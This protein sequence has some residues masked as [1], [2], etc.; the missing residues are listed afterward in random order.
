MKSTE[1]LLV[2]CAGACPWNYREALEHL[3]S[4]GMKEAVVDY[5]LTDASLERWCTSDSPFECSEAT[6]FKS[7][8]R[9]II[10]QQLA[11]SAASKIYGRFQGLFDDID[12]TPAMVIDKGMEI[13]GVGLSR[14]KAEFILDLSRAMTD[15]RVQADKIGSMCNADLSAMLCS[16]RGIGQWTCDMYVYFTAHYRAFRA[17]K[18]GRYSPE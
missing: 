2:H 10:Y 13:Q 1:H 7:L 14:R 3:S 16:V 5:G 6:V 12:P 18:K 9:T 15:G 4:S 17:C 8:C 11:G